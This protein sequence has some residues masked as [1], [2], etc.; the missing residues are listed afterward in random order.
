MVN[1]TIT[2]PD[3]KVAEL[4][5][6]FL[7]IYPIPTDENGELLYTILAWF[8]M[9]LYKQIVNAYRSGKRQKMWDEFIIEY[10][11]E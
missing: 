11:L 7:Y 3:D 4:A 9:W 6:Y 8:K 1:I 10:E 5:T 2:I